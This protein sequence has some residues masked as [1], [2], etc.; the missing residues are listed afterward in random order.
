[1]R[2]SFHFSRSN[3]KR[4]LLARTSSR[5]QSCNTDAVIEISGDAVRNSWGANC[6]WKRSCGKRRDVGSSV[7]DRRIRKC[8]ERFTAAAQTNR[9]SDAV[10]KKAALVLNQVIQHTPEHQELACGSA[11]V[12]PF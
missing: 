6:L 7:N 12:R 5:G 4:S 11:D 1:M 10:Q 2:A 8:L 9:G 3:R